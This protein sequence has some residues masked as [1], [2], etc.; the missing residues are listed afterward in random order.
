MLIVADPGLLEFE[1]VAALRALGLR[2]VAMVV[3]QQ[4]DELLRAA[5]ERYEPPDED[6]LDELPALD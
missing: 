2:R 5:R 4:M 3:E 6:E 1:I